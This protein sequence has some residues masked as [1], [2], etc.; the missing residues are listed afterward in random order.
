MDARQPTR[1]VSPMEER[2]IM[3]ENLPERFWRASLAAKRSSAALA[4]LLAFALPGCIATRADPPAGT[5]PSAP[6][7]PGGLQVRLVFGDSADL[8]LFVTDPSLETTYFGNNPSRAGG[9]LA[10]DIRCDDDAPRVETVTF[11]A[12]HAGR[13]R[14]A[15]DHARACGRQR[16]PVPYRIEAVAG[17]REWRAE[18]EIAPGKFQNRALEFELPGSQPGTDPTAR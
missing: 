1:A 15:V 14:V 18:A 5:P 2:K 8:D 11:R 9:T 17:E 7:P 6:P 13:Y 10:Q 3:R 4:L 12:A 16:G